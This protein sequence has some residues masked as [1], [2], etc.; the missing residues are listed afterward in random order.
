MLQSI[1]GSNDVGKQIMFGMIRKMLIALL[2]LS[3]ASF[4]T[5]NNSLTLTDYYPGVALLSVNNVSIDVSINFEEIATQRPHAQSELPPIP[6]VSL[7]EL[8]DENSVCKIRQKEAT[9]ALKQHLVSLMDYVRQYKKRQIKIAIK[10][11]PKLMQYEAEV[12][13]KKATFQ[14]KQEKLRQRQLAIITKKSC[15]TVFAMFAEWDKL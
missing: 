4:S 11:R 14:Y 6:T 13:S 7:D 8:V 9:K 15:Q 3:A 2:A 1:D 5:A 12:R 10:A